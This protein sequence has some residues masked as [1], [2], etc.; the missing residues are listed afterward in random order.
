MVSLL[1]VRQISYLGFILGLFSL[2][3]SFNR[4][5]FKMF[6]FLTTWVVLLQFITFLTITIIPIK[7][8]HSNLLIITS[9]T[10]GWFVFVLF[11]FYI[12]PQI[13]GKDHI[14][15]WAH[16]LSHGVLHFCIVLI[17][18]NSKLELKLKYYFLSV[19]FTLAY[20]FAL[21]LP[22]KFWNGITIYP[23]FFEE[24]GPTAVYIFGSLGLSGLFFAV[25][26]AV[27]TEKNK[28]N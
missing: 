5:G 25:G 12:Y 6:F 16:V 28:F 13:K 10:M 9:W 1:P 20:L 23:K 14:P 19:V 17:F 22:L 4:S 8:I 18:L 21:L 2:A 11:W 7:R 26:K 3:S 24:F 15:L 27:H